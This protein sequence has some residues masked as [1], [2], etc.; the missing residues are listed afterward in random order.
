M[1]YACSWLLLLGMVVPVAADGSGLK[2]A[3]QRWLRG[4]YEEA[5]S[6][7]E[8]LAQDAKLKVPAF[9]YTTLSRALRSDGC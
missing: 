9:G 7:Y 4:N 1:K 3:R 8:T 2:D 5:R 6:K